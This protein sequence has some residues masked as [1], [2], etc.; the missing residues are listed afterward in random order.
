MHKEQGHHPI[1]RLSCGR[2]RPQGNHQSERQTVLLI[3]ALFA[4]SSVLSVTKIM[5]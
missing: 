2:T 4:Q 1:L 5:I 3:D